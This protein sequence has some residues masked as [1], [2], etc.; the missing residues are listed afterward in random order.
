MLGA[1]NGDL[2]VYRL[3]SGNFSSSY[4]D[5]PSSS[6]YNRADWVNNDYYYVVSNDSTIYNMKKSNG[7]GGSDVNNQSS[8]SSIGYSVA[9]NKDN[10]EYAVGLG[11]GVLNIYRTASY[12]PIYTDLPGGGEIRA[13][14]F[15]YDSA[16]M[17]AA[18]AIGTVYVYKRVCG[19]GCVAG[20]F[21]STNGCEYCHDVIWG[22]RV[23]RNS[24][25][26]LACSLGYAFNSSSSKCSRCEKFVTGCL[27]CS[28]SNSCEACLE[29]YYL[30]SATSCA[31][32]SVPACLTCS[33]ATT[34]QVCSKG[35]FLNST[36]SCEYCPTLIP[37]CLRCLTNT[38]CIACT[39]GFFASGGSCTPCPTNCTTCFNSTNCTQCY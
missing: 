33:D 25:V 17:Y 27:S 18:S 28:A 37:N 26:C 20:Q 12:T 21:E 34:C 24:S 13:I 9:V 15:A 38:T 32:C 2:E 16:T 35:A 30:A 39:R 31:R 36:N 7:G 11:N 23:C 6:A 4:S 14:V 8:L 19:S 10:T 22:C 29:G 3:N 5:S 1:D